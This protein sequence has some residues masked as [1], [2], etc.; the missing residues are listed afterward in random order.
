MIAIRGRSDRRGISSRRANTNTPSATVATNTRP[1]A[2]APGPMWWLAS[3]MPTNA[4]A[5]R[6]TVTNAATRA[7]SVRVRVTARSTRGTPGFV[8]SVGREDSAPLRHAEA[9]RLGVPLQFGLAVRRGAAKLVA[10]LVLRLDVHERGPWV[11]AR[12]AAVE[13]LVA[14]DDLEV[15]AGAGAEHVDGNNPVRA[16]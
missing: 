5:Q 13:A 4:D 9:F 8:R 15:L 11:D 6:K 12:A 2:S 10:V 7:R 14:V 1:S 16:A 3:R